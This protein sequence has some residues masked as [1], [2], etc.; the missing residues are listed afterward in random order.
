M[1]SDPI[2]FIIGNLPDTCSWGEAQRNTCCFILVLSLFPQLWVTTRTG[3]CVLHE[4]NFKNSLLLS[5]KIGRQ[6]DLK[7]TGALIF[8]FY[9]YLYVC[10]RERVEEITLPPTYSYYFFQWLGT[11]SWLWQEPQGN[12]LSFNSKLF[13][14]LCGPELMILRYHKGDKVD[15]G[16]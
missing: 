11:P 2:I 13:H 7:A 9:V 16:Q 10:W 15:T 3:Y 8:I 6:N 5:S 4:Q 14:S 1:N 12:G